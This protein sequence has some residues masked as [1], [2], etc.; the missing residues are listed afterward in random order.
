MLNAN[1]DFV[2]DAKNLWT[3]NY[4]RLNFPSFWPN[5]Y[6]SRGRVSVGFG[7]TVGA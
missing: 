1:P 5:K 6:N 3:L 4:H 2:A 7:G